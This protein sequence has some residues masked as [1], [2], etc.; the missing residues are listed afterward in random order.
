MDSVVPTVRVCLLQTVRV[1]P[2]Q[3]VVTR[4]TS[5]SKP[6]ADL[7]VFEPNE[8]VQQECGILMEDSLCTKV[9]ME[10]FK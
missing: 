4:V 5:N 1:P 6:L 9:R 2:Q 8:E 10:L 3:C 7:L